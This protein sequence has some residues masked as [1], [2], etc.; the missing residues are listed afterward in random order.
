MRKIIENSMIDQASLHKILEC[1]IEEFEVVWQHFRTQNVVNN[2]GWIAIRPNVIDSLPERARRFKPKLLEAL[3]AFNEIRDSWTNKVTPNSYMG[4]VVTATLS[5]KAMHI[6]V[7]KFSKQFDLVKYTNKVPIQEGSL[8][9]KEIVKKVTPLG[10]SLQLLSN[11]LRSHFGIGHSALLIEL[12]DGR[13]CILEHTGHGAGTKGIVV[14]D[15]KS[16]EPTLHL[17]WRMGKTIDA[18]ADITIEDCLKV[19][20][21]NVPEYSMPYSNCY[22]VANCVM[23]FATGQDKFH[24]VLLC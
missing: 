18:K 6:D 9:N 8:T 21:I 17:G 23:T 14:Q 22:D 16:A 19:A 24:S 12:S 2:D 4:K 20:R 15:T 13:F 10:R 5:M 3:R 7:S 1:T 11:Y